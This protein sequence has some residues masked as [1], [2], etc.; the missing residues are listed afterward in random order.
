MSFLS[1]CLAQEYQSKTIRFQ[2]L[3]PGLV[4]TKMTKYDEANGWHVVSTKT[5][6]KQAVD[7]LGLCT[8]CCGSVAHDI[9][10][11]GWFF[12]GCSICFI[13]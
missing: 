9:Q 11:N 13:Y 4:A 6:A 7:A 5:F 10:V 1:E 2:C 3:F 8:I 12:C